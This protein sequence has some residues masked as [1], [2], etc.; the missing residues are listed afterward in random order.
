MG[1]VLLAARLLLSLAAA[2]AGSSCP[3]SRRGPV[4]LDEGFAAGRAFGAGGTPSAVLV[5]AAGRVGAPLAAGGE[6]VLQL[7]AALSPTGDALAASSG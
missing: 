7:L 6:A 5:D 3:S 1:A 2:S 4:L